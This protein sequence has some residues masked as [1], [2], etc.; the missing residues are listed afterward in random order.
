MLETLSQEFPEILKIATLKSPT[1]DCYCKY[2]RNNLFLCLKTKYRISL[3]KRL[4]CLFKNWTLRRGAH[5]REDAYLKNLK[6][7]GK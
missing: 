7:K 1:G 6:I 3:N 5:S 2:I 4:G